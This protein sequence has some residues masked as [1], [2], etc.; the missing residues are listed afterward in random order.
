VNYVI[1]IDEVGRGPLAGP[2]VV[3]ALSLPRGM[4]FPKHLGPLKD[5]KQLTESAREKW[6]E[7]LRDHAQVNYAVAKV[8]SAVIDRINISAAANLAAMRAC[9]RLTVPNGTNANAQIFLD[10]GLYLKN[11]AVSLA[12]GAKTVIKGD[13]H[14][15]A[16][17]AASI[18][19]KV[20]RDRL[21]ARLAKRHP[22]YGLEVHKGY[23]TALH[24]RRIRKLGAS[25][26]HR[27]TF[28]A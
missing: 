15:A 14:I 26:I 4:R 1:G 16:V 21:M 6:F 24:R 22:G 25:P 17:A 28:L 20:T 5:S 3:A 19:A 18:V 12:R 27:L 2:V 10:G 11:K 23:G 8:H 13:E 7:Y 9:D